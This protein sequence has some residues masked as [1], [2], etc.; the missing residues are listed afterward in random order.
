MEFRYSIKGSRNHAGTTKMD[1]FPAL[2][3]FV[4][5]RRNSGLCSSIGPT[6]SQMII[7]ES[8]LALSNAL[9][10]ISARAIRLT[11]YFRNLGPVLMV[12]AARIPLLSVPRSMSSNPILSPL[13][14]IS[15]DRTPPMVKLFS[16]RRL[17]VRV[18]TDVLP[19]P[20]SPVRMKSFEVDL[21]GM[22]LSLNVTRVMYI[23]CNKRCIKAKSHQV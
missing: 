20:G 14:L 16:F 13:S 11:R 19:T 1:G 23:L 6:S 15:R 18:N 21:S 17:I 10:P 22:I 3:Q 12:D 4:T 2:A 9:A 8:F 7:S 5:A